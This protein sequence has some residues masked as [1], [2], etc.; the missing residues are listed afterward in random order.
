MNILDLIDGFIT[1]QSTLPC[2]T[3]QETPF[4]DERVFQNRGGLQA[5]VSFP[6]FPSTFSYVFALAPIFARSRS[7]KCFK[8]AESPKET[9]ATQATFIFLGTVQLPEGGWG[10][11]M[12]KI[13]LKIK[14][15]PPSH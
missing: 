1:W 5:S 3:N 15:H 14:S 7:E 4:V 6:P 11:E 9:L 2:R 10:W 12:G 13:R 8:P